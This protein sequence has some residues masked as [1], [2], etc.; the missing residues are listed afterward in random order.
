M[1]NVTLRLEDDVLT[2]LR[3]QASAAGVSLS[4]LVAAQFKPKQPKISQED[5]DLK[6]L[7]Q[8]FEG[9]GYY[10]VAHNWP[11]RDEIHER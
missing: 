1:K 4:R 3:A 10:G 5:E 7:R 6:I 11:T 8:F 9:E 2:E